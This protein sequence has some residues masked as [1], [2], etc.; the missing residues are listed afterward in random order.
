M[1]I[2]VLLE[3]GVLAVTVGDTRPHA[4][5]RPAVSRT[6]VR[7]AVQKCRNVMYEFYSDLNSKSQ[8]QFS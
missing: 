2:D 5:R 1:E 7:I 3:G 8:I 4:G 6:Y